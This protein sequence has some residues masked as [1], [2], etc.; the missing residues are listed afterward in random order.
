MSGLKL[1]LVGKQQRVAGRMMSHRG[2]H[3]IHFQAGLHIIGPSAD[4]IVQGF[5]VAI[6]MGATLQARQLL[7]RT[8]SASFSRTIEQ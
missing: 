2:S 4:E 7:P 1:V 5:A 6:R 3:S 8:A